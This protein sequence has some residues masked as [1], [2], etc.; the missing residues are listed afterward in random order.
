MHKLTDQITVVEKG[1]GYTVL[2]ENKYR[3][4][5]GDIIF[6]PKGTSHTFY[7]SSKKLMLMHYHT[8][9]TFI[10]TDLYEINQEEI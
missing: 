4:S 7:S 8:P 9:K 1:S 10:K 5:T 6:I 2:N 3:V